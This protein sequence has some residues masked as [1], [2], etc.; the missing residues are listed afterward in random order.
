M[1]KPSLYAR[2]RIVLLRSAGIKIQRVRDIEK[3]G[4]KTSRSSVGAF[5]VMV[6]TLFSNNQRNSLFNRFLTKP[7]CK[8]ENLTK[9]R[10]RDTGK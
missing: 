5:H 3:E 8:F 9:R 1:G 4:I 7:S 10:M 2:N 6:I